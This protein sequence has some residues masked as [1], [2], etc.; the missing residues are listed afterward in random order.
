MKLKI[1]A[2]TTSR[3]LR[4]F[5]QDN[6]VTTG[7]GLTGLA[8]NTS[9]LKCYYSRV[10]ASS[11]TAVTL[12]TA[13]AGT[14]SS[15]GF[16]ALDGTNMPGVYELHI[17]NAAIASSATA[18][19]V[20]L[21]GAAGMAP[22][23][24]E[25]ELDAVDYQDSGR[26]GL[27]SLPAAAAD[28]A[29]GLPVIGTNNNQFSST[30]GNVKLANNA[31]NNNTFSSGAITAATFAANAL[32]AVWDEATGSHTT[33]G[34]YGLAAASDT[35][36]TTTLLSRLSA[37][38]AGYLDNLSAG[39]VATASALTTVGGN[40]TT[41]LGQTGTTGVLIAS[42]AITASTIAS[43]AITSAKFG[44]NAL[45][46]VWD[47]LKSAHTTA[48]TYGAYL[49]QASSAASADS[50][51]VTTLLSRLSATRAGY[52]DNI[53]TAAPSAATIATQ[54]WSTTIP[55]S[56]TSGQ[57]G[58]ALGNVATGSPPTAAAIATQVWS[59]ALPGS[60]TSGQAGYIL[61]N[62]SGGGG[63][64]PWSV[65]LPGAYSAGTAGYIV[66]NNPDSAGITTLLSR[67]TSTRAGYLDNLSAGGV[68]TASALTT[69]GGN[70]TTILGQT[71]T[72]GVVVA[73]GSK[74]G[75]SLTQSF[76]ANFASLSIDSSGRTVLAPAGLD[77]IAVETGVNVRQALSPILAAA[78][79]VLSGAGTGTI[80]VKG[81]NVA[82]TRI[83]A[84]T[85]SS[86]NRS[87]ITLSLPS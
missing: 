7:A 64:D 49:D 26:M 3:I 52:L 38:R 1:K 76:P 19:H 65:A 11:A 77:A 5:V 48:N 32:G 78:A 73:S 57:A 67:V 45:G 16:V 23:L 68:A 8:Y 17:P 41:I 9:N 55:G 56:F 13:T 20:M 75:Y 83:T 37:T 36:G 61:P 27:T 14:Y 31:I 63:T 86:G 87:S 58:Y 79:G 53:A 84:T 62:I 85:D 10:G 71:G 6:S 29:G 44:A 24:I 72:T 47:E 70:V 60:F 43:A 15:G 66:G 22:V 21:W 28:G 40:V 35:A 4:V 12:V 74:T 33:A 39:G 46:A 42:G 51:G 80:V 59:T 30:L 82:T 25:I 54:V 34:T 50:A 2:G 81:G 18:V 69:V